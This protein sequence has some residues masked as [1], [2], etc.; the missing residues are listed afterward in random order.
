MGRTGGTRLSFTDFD[1]SQ[2]L[3]LYWGPEDANAVELA[4]DCVVNEPGETMALDLA[5]SS[6]ANGMARW[7]GYAGITYWDN[8]W[9]DDVLGT[10]FTLVTSDSTGPLS[11]IPGGP[12]DISAPAVITVTG[13]YA[14]DMLMEAY[15]G[16]SWWP[17]L[18]LFDALHTRPEHEYCAVSNVDHGFFYE[19]ETRVYLPMVLRA[20]P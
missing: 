15:Y 12:L 19:T 4:F 16:G 6:L 14:A 3:V 10:R 9:I 2:S 8:G 5:Q 17:S 18:E 1:L 20:Y 7:T 13:S 11:L